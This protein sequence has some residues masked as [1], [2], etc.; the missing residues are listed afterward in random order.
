MNREFQSCTNVPLKPIHFNLNPFLTIAKIP[1]LKISLHKPSTT[2]LCIQV[3][4]QAISFQTTI[5]FRT[6]LPPFTFNK[7]YSHSLNLSYISPTFLHTEFPFISISLSY[8]KQNFVF[9]ETPLVINQLWTATTEFFRWQIYE[10]VKWQTSLPTD[11]NTLSFF[12]VRSQKHKPT[13]SNLWLS[14][15]S[16]LVKT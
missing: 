6:K 14:I 3:L 13:S 15:L 12:A 7:M 16:C 2:F 9:L 10:S 11:L 8:T 1:F 5:S 4:S